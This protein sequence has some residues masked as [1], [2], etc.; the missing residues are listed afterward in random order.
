MPLPPPPAHAGPAACSLTPVISQPVPP[1]Q[2]GEP[3][4]PHLGCGRL[5][6][7]WRT[8]GAVLALGLCTAA[9]AASLTPLTL[10][11][12]DG[13][14]AQVLQRAL[15][16]PA[17]YNAARAAWLDGSHL[18]WAGTA[19][20]GRFRLHHSRQG[21]LALAAGD[22]VAGSDGALTL[23]VV[24]ADAE[25]ASTRRFSHIGAGPTLAV[26]AA[27]LPRLPGLLRDQVVLTREDALGRVLD[28]T[29]VQLAG[30]LDA[31]YAA[32]GTL[33]DLGAQLKPP[34]MP[35]TAGVSTPQRRTSFR[36]WAPTAR[37][38]QLCVHGTP[39]GRATELLPLR[40]DTATGAWH[41]LHPDDLAGRY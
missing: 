1:L 12:C 26:R 33:Q 19:A 29:H 25:T 32:A 10:A 3:V 31:T 13:P 7:W 17:A 35:Q 18:R 11:D 27:D 40:R 34:A 16:M 22:R 38:V 14:H 36:V 8:S 21:L 15:P 4:C 2:P 6:R 41:H 37:Q 23:Q 5:Q 24:P 9:A 30:V 28:A 39:N 20:E